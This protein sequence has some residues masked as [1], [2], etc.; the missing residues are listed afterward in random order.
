MKTTKFFLL[1]A[2]A[3]AFASCSNDNEPVI[4]N[5]EPVAVKVYA[6]IGAMQSRAA[7]TSWDAGD[8]IGISCVSAST[9]YN[10][11]QYRTTGDGNFTHINGY[12]HG[13]F[14]E[15]TKE[16]TF[17]AYYPFTG[18]N[19]VLNGVNPQDP[20]GIIRDVKFDF[21]YATATASRKEPVLSFSGDN[22]F[23]HCMT[24]LVINVKLDPNSGFD[25]E[26][27]RSGQYFLNG[28][29]HSGTFNT[30]TG[31]AE[32]TGDPSQN[33][34]INDYGVLEDN[35]Q[36][37]SLILYPQENAELTLRGNLAG[38]DYVSSVI[39]PALETGKSYT[40][41]ITVKKTGL[42]VSSCTIADW[43]QGNGA[44]ED[45]DATMPTE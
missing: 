25:A 19:G 32:A 12:A 43:N 11:V 39:K 17:T 16:V 27:V 14:F 31:E 29:K 42:V 37:Y 1:A 40:Y 21:M 3:M 30:A 33:W 18:S 5:G 10:N 41:T 2:T 44:G 9:T 26:H 7:G 13:I 38:E 4:D 6:G 24:R 45:I 8:E 20:D 23:R 35:V 22:A 15:D 36:T 34:K 28:I